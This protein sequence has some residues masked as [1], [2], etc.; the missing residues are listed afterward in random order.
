MKASDLSLVDSLL[1]QSSPF[2]HH[3]LSFSQQE[4]TEDKANNKETTIS[5]VLHDEISS[6]HTLLSI[7]AAFL[8]L[9]EALESTAIM[10][11]ELS[12]LRA[13]ESTRKALKD[14]KSKPTNIDNERERE[15]LESTRKER[16]RFL[17]VD[18]RWRALKAF[19]DTLGT[20]EREYCRVS[21]LIIDMRK[22]VLE[23]NF[24]KAK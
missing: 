18:E 1:S 10:S 7:R 17:R 9:R 13:K 11:V 15:I 4:K 22:D 2:Y 12:L 16:R 23:G 19:G 21:R 6:Y 20:K 3:F 24:R 5:Q 8:S 14:K